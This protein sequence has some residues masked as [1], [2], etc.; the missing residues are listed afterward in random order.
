[1]TKKNRERQQQ[2]A[3]GKN[4]KKNNN[5]RRRYKKK[6]A[7]EKEKLSAYKK[8]T[9]FEMAN[10]IATKPAPGQ[11]RPKITPLTVAPTYFTHSIRKTCQ[12]VVDGSSKEEDDN[13]SVNSKTP[14]IQP[15]TPT[16]EYD[17]SF[18]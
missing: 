17:F 16:G 6:Q 18:N 4:C 14:P 2:T 11:S 7:E 12:E 10:A 13:F 3:K 15:E 5:R 8:V 1:M 9:A